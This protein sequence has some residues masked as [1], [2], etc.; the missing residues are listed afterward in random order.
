MK[1]YYIWVVNFCTPSTEM[2]SLCC[3]ERLQNK[4]MSE[5]VN[6]GRRGGENIKRFQSDWRKGLTHLQCQKD[7][8]HYTLYTPRGRVKRKKSWEPQIMFTESD[9]MIPKYMKKIFSFKRRGEGT[10]WNGKVSEIFNCLTTRIK[11]RTGASK[12]FS[13]YHCQFFNGITVKMKF[14][15]SITEHKQLP[16][17]QIKTSKS[18]SFFFFIAGEKADISKHFQPINTT[19]LA[20]WFPITYHSKMVTTFSNQMKCF[21]ILCHQKKL[22]N[23]PTWN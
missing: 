21:T 3:S 17:N 14:M 5:L 9:F 8:T 2:L 22:H 19:V 7:T 1:S 15:T 6:M 10:L 16:E 20:R 4:E 23:L 13:G 12:F 18:R 11:G